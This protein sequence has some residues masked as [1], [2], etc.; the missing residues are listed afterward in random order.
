MSIFDL[1]LGV[2]LFLSGLIH[3]LGASIDWARSIALA[4][5]EL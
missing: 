2:V 4:I 1:V 5:G 3:L